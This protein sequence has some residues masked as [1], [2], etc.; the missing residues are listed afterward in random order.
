[1]VREVGR[2]RWESPAQW[3][4]AKQHPAPEALPALVDAQM[5][6]VRAVVGLTRKVLVCD[7]DNTLWGGVIGEDGLTGIRLGPGSPEGEAYS[8]LQEYLLEL[9][10]RGLLLAVC[11]KNNPEDARLPFEQHPHMRLRLD[12]IA[13]FVASWD[14]KVEQIRRVAHALSLGTDSFVFLDDNPFERTWVRSQLPEVAAPELTTPFTYVRELDRHRY[15]QTLTLSNEDQARTEM[16]RVEGARA[17]LRTQAAS[18]DE[19]LEQLRMRATAVAITPA[20]LA[21][22]TQL[23]NK[24]N[25]FNLTTMRYTEA[26][27][28]RIAGD[29]RG[30]ARAFHLADRFGDHGLIGVLLCR[31]AEPDGWEIDTW[32]MSCRVLGR[33]MEHLMFDRL[34]EAARAHGIARVVGVYRPTAKNGQVADLLPRLGFDPVPGPEGE[35]RFERAVTSAATA[36]ST[37]IELV[38]S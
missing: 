6:H 4:T 28:E 5:A 9:K 1:M 7:L 16:Y 35:T 8:A 11:S 33:R 24:T 13:A 31:A 3:C 38:P 15:F 10:G 29:P 19:F 34:V 21:R 18:L 14:D 25:Q 22:V 12:D 17:V 30:W 23:V 2:D 32:L 27:I 26:D 20:N 37:F 36:T